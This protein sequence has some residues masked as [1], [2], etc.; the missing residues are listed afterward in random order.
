M[1]VQCGCKIAGE[2][3]LWG[4]SSKTN[5]AAA[6][7]SLFIT[8]STCLNPMFLS[9]FILVLCWKS[10]KHIS[11]RLLCSA[12][13]SNRIY[14]IRRLHD[15][16]H[17]LNIDDMNLCGSFRLHDRSSLHHGTQCGVVMWLT[18]VA[19]VQPTCQS[20]QNAWSLLITDWFQNC[21]ASW[22]SRWFWGIIGLR[23]DPKAVHHECC[24]RLFPSASSRERRTVPP[25]L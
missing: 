10:D 4:P 21:S 15:L 24:R 23:A 22:N 18:V 7:L 19:V 2:M 20:K 25:L 16:C 12:G 8:L 14:C 9:I 5:W 11:S 3:W 17:H 13:I 1:L 6:L